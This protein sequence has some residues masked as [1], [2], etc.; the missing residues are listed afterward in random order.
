MTPSGIIFDFDGVLVDS[1]HV[2][3]EAFRA[4]FM[5][6]N[7]HLEEILDFHIANGGI[8]RFA[9]FEYIHRSIL[10]KDLS[11]DRSRELGDEFSRLVMKKVIESPAMPGALEFIRK[12]FEQIPLF[13]ASATPQDE[14]QEIVS[15]RGLSPFFQDIHG[16]PR[17]KADI[18]RVILDRNRLKAGEVPFVGDAINDYMASLETG[19]P[20]YAFAVDGGQGAFPPQATIIRSFPELEQHLFGS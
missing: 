20:F 12:Y 6:E 9:K 17:S 1:V 11:E 2:K 13:I 16:A 14:L 3:T 19:S 4:L 7:Q 5:H 10:K 8:S 18:I 15:K